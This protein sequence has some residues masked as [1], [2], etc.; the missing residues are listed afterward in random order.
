MKQK[1]YEPLFRKKSKEQ[2]QRSYY[3]TL[4]GNIY[5][6]DL[7]DGKATRPLINVGYPHKGSV[8]VDPRGYP[9]LY[10]GQGIDEKAGKRVPIGYRIFSL[11]TTNSFSLSTVWISLP[12]ENGVPLTLRP[13]LTARMT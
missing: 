2:S 3:A 1:G 13:L 7:D 10:A 6:L 12:L 9:L 11:L 8:T 5:F 4:D